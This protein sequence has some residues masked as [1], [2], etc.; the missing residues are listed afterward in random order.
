MPCVLIVGLT[1]ALVFNLTS[2]TRKGL[3]KEGF[4]VVL[5][6]C[7]ALSDPVIKPQIGWWF[8]MLLH[9]VL[10]YEQVGFFVCLFFTFQA[11]SCKGQHSISYTL[12]RNHT[13]VVEYSH[14]KDTD[15]FQVKVRSLLLWHTTAFRYIHT[16]YISFSAITVLLY[17]QKT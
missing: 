10:C 5:L 15:M 16:P 2:P 13:V 7:L 3:C 12:S 11:V 14:D 8:I 17:S 6:C 9:C 4:T 1:F